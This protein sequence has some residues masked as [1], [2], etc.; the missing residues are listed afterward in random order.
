MVGSQF[1]QSLV[2]KLSSVV[3]KFES[4]V[5]NQ[6]DKLKLI[7]QDRDLKQSLQTCNE[8]K[9]SIEK[10]NSPISLINSILKSIK[11][12]IKIIKNLIKILKKLIKTITKI[13][14]KPLTPLTPPLIAPFP[15]GVIPPGVPLLYPSIGKLVK[16]NQV[17]ASTT[18]VI[19][20]MES[21]LDNLSGFI[22]TLSDMI[23]KITN[24]LQNI[25]PLFLECE[26]KLSIAKIKNIVPSNISDNFQNIDNIIDDIVKDLNSEIPIN[27]IED[28][29]SYR[30]Y[31]F[32]IREISE[33]FTS[34]NVKRRYAVAINSQGIVAFQGGPSFATNKQILISELKFLIDNELLNNEVEEN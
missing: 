32:E 15:A 3:G 19:S 17:S 4:M 31:S 26:Q 34:Q 27:L 23:K 6:I 33:E 22:N 25:K 2:K 7:A 28:E 30:G 13:P 11:G 20:Q 5:N 9:K 14:L 16:L 12:I 24:N 18:I 1:A 29:L 8:A 21:F 10:L